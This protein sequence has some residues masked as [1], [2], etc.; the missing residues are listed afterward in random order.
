MAT[1]PT[2]KPAAAEPRVVPEPPQAHDPPRAAP[3]IDPDRA[4][5]QAH[6]GG[7]PAMIR[8]DQPMRVVLQAVD[9]NVV[10]AGLQELPM[11]V[12][13]PVFAKIQQ[14]LEAPPQPPPQPQP[15]GVR[16]NGSSAPD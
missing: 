12:A 13:A 5:A 1:K 16:V 2:A 8:P 14:Q 10:L 15:S 6:V 3:V 4:A 7:R 9:W 11:R